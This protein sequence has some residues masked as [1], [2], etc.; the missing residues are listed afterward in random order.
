MNFKRH[1]LKKNKSQCEF[2]RGVLSAKDWPEVSGQEVAFWGRSNVGKSSLLNALMKRK[3]LAKVSKTPGR[4]Q[5]INFYQLQEGVRYVDL[6]GYGYACVPDVLQNMWHQHVLDYVLTRINLCLVVVLVD[7]RRDT[8]PQDFQVVDFLER[9][10]I[11]VQC[12]YTKVDCISFS[13]RSFL[14]LNQ[15]EKNCFCISAHTGE[16]VVKLRSHIFSVVRARCL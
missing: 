9:S 14:E 16:G 6:P 13:Q 15:K 3:G 11:P 4:T 12:I 1:K 8:S 10:R 2:L 5:T 7:G